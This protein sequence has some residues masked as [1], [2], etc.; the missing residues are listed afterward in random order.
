[1]HMTV[2]MSDEP[3]YA[4]K[5]TI[6]T[7]QSGSKATSCWN[8]WS[9]RSA[10]MWPLRQCSAAGADRLFPVESKRSAAALRFAGRMMLSTCKRAFEDTI[11]SMKMLFG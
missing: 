11:P 4:E 10:G 7:L 3:H 5:M 1:M 8:V 2:A 9:V 6:C